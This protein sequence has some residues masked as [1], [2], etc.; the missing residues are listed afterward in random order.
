MIKNRKIFLTNI[1]LI[2]LFVACKK[3]TVTEV[4]N[5]DFAIEYQFIN[6]GDTNVRDVIMHTFQKVIIF[7]EI[8][9]FDTVR[10]SVT[11]TKCGECIDYL[12]VFVRFKEMQY[13][14]LAA[15]KGYNN[16]GTSALGMVRGRTYLGDTISIA[17]GLNQTLVFKWPSDTLNYKEVIY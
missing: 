2:L 15:A 14:T 8:K 13:S 16:G 4:K 7:N 5:D 3:Q 1:I 12:K 11:K 9:K 17:S 6:Q 10:F